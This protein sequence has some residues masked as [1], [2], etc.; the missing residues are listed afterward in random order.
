MEQKYQEVDNSDKNWKPARPGA[1]I[2]K[3][4][5]FNRASKQKDS[6]NSCDSQYK[7]VNDQAQDASLLKAPIWAILELAV[8]WEYDKLE[9]VS[10]CN[11]RNCRR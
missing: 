4:V 6:G 10:K 3:Q 2:V 11:N 8:S 7:C 9:H 1:Q 5:W